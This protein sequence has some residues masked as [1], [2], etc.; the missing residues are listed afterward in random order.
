MSNASR[1][2]SWRHAILQSD[3]PATTRHVLLT[4]SCFM[5]EVGGGCYPTTK[6]LAAATGLSERAVCTHIAAAAEAGWLK[7]SEHGFRG[8]KWKNHQYKAAWPNAEGTEGRSV[9]SE[10]K[11]L[12][13]VPRGTER[14]SAKALNDVQC[15][16]PD[17]SI[18][19]PVD[20]SA[21]ERAPAVPTAIASKQKSP[22]HELLAVLDEARADAVIEHRK[23]IRKP[24]TAHAARLLAGK[25]R[26]CPDPNAAAD[27]MIVSGWQGFEPSWLDGRERSPKG[28]APPAARPRPADPLFAICQAELSIPTPER[29]HAIERS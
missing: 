12:N 3:L 1:A 20:K 8:Q 25:F 19:S 26:Q 24:L 21:R 4:I 28:P 29:T 11:A 2:W 14:R 17:S 9:P 18:T 16:S 6:D 22:R 23:R 15:N 5:N 10:A 13:V 7:V 27:A